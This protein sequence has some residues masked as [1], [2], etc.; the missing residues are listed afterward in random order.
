MPTEVPNPEQ[1]DCDSVTGNVVL[2]ESKRAVADAGI[3]EYYNETVDDYMAWSEEG[4]L[5]YGYWRPWLNPFARK[6]MLEEMNRLIFKHL[7][8]A[9]LQSGAVADLGCGFGAVS[10]FGSQLHPKLDFH[11]VTISP[12]QVASARE[13]QTTERVQYYCA[14]YHSLPL[15]DLS[16]DRVFFLESL[17]HSEQPEAALSEVCRVLK[18]GGRIVMTDGF[19]ARP[20]D[21]TSPVFRHIVTEVAHNWAVPMFH[22]I[23]VARKWNCDGQLKLVEDIECGWRLGPSALHAI[24]LTVIHFLKLAIR[25]KVTAWQ[26]RHLRASAFTVALGLYRRH[27]RYHLLAFEKTA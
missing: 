8:L 13:R 20:L 12:E 23:N 17:C 15:E 4:Y 11:A 6:P 7:G 2:P 10:R 14:D 18:P 26:W 9:E 21:K 1:Q 24:H 3:S 25:R 16:I 5:H 19:L 27:F 22:E